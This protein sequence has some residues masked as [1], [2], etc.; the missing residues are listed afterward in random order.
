MKNGN[1]GVGAKKK[2]QRLEG[3]GGKDWQG[4]SAKG[5]GIVEPGKTLTAQRRSC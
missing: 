3:P 4:E 5:R 1:E 2:G